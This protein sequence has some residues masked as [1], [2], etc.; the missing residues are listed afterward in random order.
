MRA[1]PGARQSASR[2]AASD[3]GLPECGLPKTPWRSSAW[4][5]RELGLRVQAAAGVVEI[6]LVL[7]VEPRVLPGPEGLDGVAVPVGVGDGRAEG[8]SRRRRARCGDRG[9]HRAMLPMA[10]REVCDPGSTAGV[11]CGGARRGAARGDVRGAARGDGRRAARRG[12]PRHD[13]GPPPPDVA[14]RATILVL[15]RPDG[16]HG[17][18]RRHGLGHRGPRTREPWSP[19]PR[20]WPSW[21]ANPGT[22]VSGA[23]VGAIV[24]REPGN[25][26]LRRHGWGHRG[27]RTRE[28]WSPAPRLGPSWAA[29]PGTVVSGATRAARRGSHGSGVP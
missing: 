29:N 14:S 8:R 27:P 18:L 22:V 21:A 7:R 25:R 20:F 9:R 3:V 11:C 2:V 5:S 1:P 6:D 26:G 10:S 23:T 17:G 19:A 28:P 4:C 15:R 13:P 16:R 24:G 12:L